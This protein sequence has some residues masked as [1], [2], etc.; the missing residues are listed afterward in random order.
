MHCK[1]FV[2]FFSSLFLNVC[3]NFAQT[4]QIDSLK[5]V[6]RYA[7]DDTN[8][9][10]VLNNLDWKLHGTG[11]YD[12]SLKYALQAQHL[13]EKLNF[14]SGLAK[15]YSTIG[16]VYQ[17]RSDHAEALKYYLLTVQIRSSK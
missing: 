10:N 6:V 7:K 15:A 3:P 9:V 16:N 2:G 8:K 13:S 4:K 17:S 12:S 11:N 1:Y 14:K 5:L